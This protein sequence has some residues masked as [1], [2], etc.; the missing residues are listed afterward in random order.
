MLPGQDHAQ[1]VC[2][3]LFGVA[4][5]IRL[6][7]LAQI[8]PEIPPKG[9][10]SDWL[11]KGDGSLEKLYKIAETV[12]DWQPLPKGNGHDPAPRLVAA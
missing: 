2:R 10:V 6:L 11:A 8:W 9:D 4:C 5:C 3:N 12:S 7:D 1:D